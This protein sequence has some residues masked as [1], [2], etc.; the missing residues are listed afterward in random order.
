MTDPGPVTV[1][2]LPV[3]VAGPETM[4]KVTLNP[5]LALAESVVGPPP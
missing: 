4:L 3:T 2:V 1:T 5:E